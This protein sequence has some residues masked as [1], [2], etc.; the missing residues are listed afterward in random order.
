M[1]FKTILLHGIQLSTENYNFDS[2]SK[3]IQQRTVLDATGSLL[4]SISIDK[5]KKRVI[6]AIIVMA[7]DD[8]IFSSNSHDVQMK[9]VAADFLLQITEYL[10]GESENTDFIKYSIEEYEKW[11]HTDRQLLLQFEMNASP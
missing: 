8:E 11:L 2:I 9:K 10:R 7:F 5:R 1:S 4:E 6:L 3:W